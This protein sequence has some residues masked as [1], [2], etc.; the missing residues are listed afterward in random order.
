PVHG[1][2]AREGPDDERAGPQGGRAGLRPGP[3]PRRH[4]RDEPLR[5]SRQRR[6]DQA[7]TD[8]HSL[9]NRPRHRRVRSRP[10]GDRREL[11]M[12]RTLRPRPW[13]SA[14]GALALLV[15]ACGGTAT[16]GG[17]SAGGAG[18]ASPAA[19]GGG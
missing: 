13:V 19:A 15:T 6:E 7:A 2:R 3:A 9:G 17:S 18:G 4:V 11:T 16:P 1:G 14:F 5:R 12:T 8:H 10:H